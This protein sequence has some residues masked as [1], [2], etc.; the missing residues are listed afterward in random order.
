MS[1]PD[2]GRLVLQGHSLPGDPTQAN[3]KKTAII[4]RMSA[5]TFA[6]LE[7]D[8]KMEIDLTGQPVM[9]YSISVAMTV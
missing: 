7:R 8:T 2:S 6:A 1:L 5:E 4:L 9:T 3:P